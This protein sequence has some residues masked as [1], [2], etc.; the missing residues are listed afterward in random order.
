MKCSVTVI[1]HAGYHQCSK[2]LL[3][4]IL[5]FCGI[6]KLLPPMCRQPEVQL[7]HWW[8]LQCPEARIWRH[9]WLWKEGRAQDHG[10]SNAVNLFS[11]LSWYFVVS[12]NCVECGY[13]SA[14]CVTEPSFIGI[15][16]YLIKTN[17][18]L[19]IVILGQNSIL[20]LKHIDMDIGAVRFTNVVLS[21]LQVSVHVLSCTTD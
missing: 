16:E 14:I 10:W 3:S 19:I 2:S 6:I 5:I 4:T 18:Y 8:L 13:R 11:A 12:S 7:C 15:S 21:L 9:Q 1:V 20:I 17:R